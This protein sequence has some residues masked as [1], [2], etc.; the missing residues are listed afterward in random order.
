MPRSVCRT[1]KCALRGFFIL[2]RS[3]NVASV[4]SAKVVA[5]LSK[6]VA[7]YVTC[8]FIS[9]LF[10]CYSRSKLLLF[11]FS[12]VSSFL[13]YGLQ[14][15]DEGLHHVVVGVYIVVRSTTGIVVRSTTGTSFIGKDYSL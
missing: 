13:L 1:N 10:L 2:P 11:R 9:F 4:A 6:V 14:D 7:G 12:D 15:L 8:Y 5:C 3:S